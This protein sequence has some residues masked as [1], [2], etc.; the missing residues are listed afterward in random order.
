MRVVEAERV[1]RRAVDERHHRRRRTV[2]E[3]EDR[4][5]RRPAPF[6][7]EHECGLNRLGLKRGDGDAD[8]VGDARE[9]VVPDAVGQVGY[10]ANG[11]LREPGADGGRDSHA[12]TSK[13]ARG[14]TGQPVT[15]AG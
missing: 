10:R 2:G 11:E 13:T 14:R 15:P 7:R 8:G 3:S 1:G 9:A 12:V 4:R 5:L 6:A